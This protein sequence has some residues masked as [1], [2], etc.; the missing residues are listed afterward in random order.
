[1][2]QGSLREERH[3]ERF[4]KDLNTEMM[5]PHVLAGCD[6]QSYMDFAKCGLDPWQYTYKMSAGVLNAH[7][8]ETGLVVYEYDNLNRVWTKPCV[9]DG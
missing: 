8:R 6:M 9:K 5:E 4:K 1:M 3:F 2:K 7:E